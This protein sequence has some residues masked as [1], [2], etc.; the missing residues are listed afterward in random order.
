MCRIAPR[1]PI[2]R[3]TTGATR[4]FSYSQRTQS[5][6]SASREAGRASHAGERF[7]GWDA[8]PSKPAGFVGQLSSGDAP[9]RI[10]G[11][12]GQAS[13][14]QLRT[15]YIPVI[16]V[17]RAAHNR[18]TV[19]AKPFARTC[20]QIGKVIARQPLSIPPPGQHRDFVAVVPDG[21]GSI[22]KAREIGAMLTLF[23]AVFIGKDRHAAIIP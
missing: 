22:R 21:I 19:Q 3:D 7:T 13:F 9:T 14:G 23:D 20:T 17:R 8:E 16:E 1:G 18:V 12:F 10:I 6:R 11:R 5:T 4:P 2:M 15:R